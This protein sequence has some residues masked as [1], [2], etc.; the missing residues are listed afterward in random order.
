VSRAV[1][2][3]IRLGVVE[4][5]LRRLIIRKPDVLRHLVESD[6]TADPPP[7]VRVEVRISPRAPA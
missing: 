3:L 5:D 7:S 2:E 1:S 6:T 4:K